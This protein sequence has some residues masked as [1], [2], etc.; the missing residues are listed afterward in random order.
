MFGTFFLLPLACWVTFCLF[1]FAEDLLTDQP[2]EVDFFYVMIWKVFQI[3]GDFALNLFIL[4]S[5]VVESRLLGKFNFW[6]KR[7]PFQYICLSLVCTILLQGLAWSRNKINPFGINR[8]IH[9]KI[10]S[11][12][13]VRNQTL[14]DWVSFSK[15]LII[16][17]FEIVLNRIRICANSRLFSN[18]TKRLDLVVMWKSR[19]ADTY[20]MVGGS[21]EIL[22]WKCFFKKIKVLRIALPLSF[23]GYSRKGL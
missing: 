18:V 14:K 2:W 15:A 16:L 9:F 1:I 12:V 11:R 8:S 13:S 20:I 4:N 6:S 10:M 5:G 19:N 3:D 23:K 22:V 17:L 21:C 7:F